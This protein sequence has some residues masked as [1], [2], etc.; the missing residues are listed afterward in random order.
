MDQLLERARQRDRGQTG[1]AGL[2]DDFW[3]SFPSGPL[4]DNVTMHIHTTQYGPVRLIGSDQLGNPR[5]YGPMGDIGAIER[6]P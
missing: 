3:G 1:A 2:G 4:G 6:I 5:P